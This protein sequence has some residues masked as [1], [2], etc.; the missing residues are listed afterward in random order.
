MADR[1]I[2]TQVGIEDLKF[3]L[4]EIAENLSA[5][6][7]ASLSKAHG[8]NL[9]SGFVDTDG[10]DRT[11]YQ[12][13]NGDVI[14]N[15]FLRFVVNNVIYFAP[16]LV[17][18]LPGQ[19][20]T[21]GAI[22]TSPEGEFDS[23]G[24]SA[25]ITDY[26]STQVEQAQSI[27][28]DVL[29]PHTRQPA[30]LTHGNF[31]V[32]LQ[33]T[34]TSLGHV[35]GTHII[36]IRISNLVYTIPAVTRIGGP[37]QA[38]RIGGIPTNL[39]VNIGSGDPNDCDVPVT[40]PFNGGTKPVEYHWQYNNASVWTDITPSPAGTLVLPGWSDGI[41]FQW[42]D[43]ST[44]TFRITSIHPGSDQTRS[45]QFRCRVTNAAVPDSGPDSGTITNVLTFTGT[46][47]TG[48]WL[49]GVARDLGYITEEDYQTD[50]QWCMEAYPPKYYNGYSWWARPLAAWFGEHPA[51]FAPIAPLIQAWT[52]EIC[53]Q[54]GKKPQGSFLGKCVMLFGVSGCLVIGTIRSKLKRLRLSTAHR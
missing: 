42:A 8:L 43:T 6:I 38:P 54:A 10:N 23:Q 22:D 49:C 45:A 14:G 4:T 2:V 26:T 16:A 25:W 40:V 37:L 52:Q 36:Q 48:K 30:Q 21:N 24:G 11:T 34:F 9:V 18:S 35:A 50:R 15:Y 32:V 41:T 29:I 53:F 7:N 27:N 28:T 33:N 20:A 13:S 51:F 31:T 1:N 5:H 46:D 39:S 44:P 3:A 19:D 17:T 12:D 47:N